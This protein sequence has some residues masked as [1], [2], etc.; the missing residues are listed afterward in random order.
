[1]RKPEAG[2]S[3]YLTGSIRFEDI[4][5]PLAQFQS[6]SLDDDYDAAIGRLKQAINNAEHSEAP[7]LQSA[8]DIDK[9]AEA[10]AQHISSRLGLR[11][12][13]K[14]PQHP[15]TPVD[16]KLVFVVMSFDAS[17]DPAYEAVKAA[18]EACGLSQ[19]ASKMFLVTTESQTK[20]LR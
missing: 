11:L 12:G 14:T 16:P 18:A 13:S 19:G 15:S 17:M 7:P 5:P 4:P 9:I 6:I 8:L 10:V 2:L 1:M 20:C 3:Q